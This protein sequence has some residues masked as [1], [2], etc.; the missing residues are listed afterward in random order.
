VINALASSKIK[1]FLKQKQRGQTP[2]V[3]FTQVS[4]AKNHWTK[5]KGVVDNS[6]KFLSVKYLRLLCRIL[7]TVMILSVSC[8]YFLYI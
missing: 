6:P 5:K 4:S 7:L 2:R 3:F 8:Q 1:I